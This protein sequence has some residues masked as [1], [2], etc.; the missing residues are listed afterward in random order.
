M[1][2]GQCAVGQQ[3]IGVA[4]VLADT[5]DQADP[6]GMAAAA[7]QGE[8]G[9]AFH[10]ARSGDRKPL[11]QRISLR[12]AGS[13]S[14]ELVPSGGGD[15]F[16]GQLATSPVGDRAVAAGIFAGGR[17]QGEDRDVLAIPGRR[18]VLGRLGLYFHGGAQQERAR[19]SAKSDF[20]LLLGE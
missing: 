3:A 6:L 10:F 15:I 7:L 4:L 2:V 1:R 9:R 12:L 11:R 14:V 20:Y 19:D 5:T 8:D 13:L 17:G 18:F 16:G